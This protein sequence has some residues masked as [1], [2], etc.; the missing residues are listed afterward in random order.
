[1]VTALACT[2]ARWRPNNWAATFG[3]PARALAKAPHSLSNCPPRAL[4]KNLMKTTDK[5]ASNRVLVVDDNPSIHADFRKILCPAGRG[6][7]DNLSG[8]EAELFGD[9]PRNEPGPLFEMDSAFQ[10]Q[11]ALAMVGAAEEQGRPYSLA[12]ID[13]RMPPGWDGIES[14]TRIW[15]QF[16]ALQVVICSAYSDYSW[17]DILNRRCR[18][19]PA[20]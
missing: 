20:G 4:P 17:E 1:M 11:E 3:P 8:L 2:A 19:P 9:S 5:I 14:I 7:A 12:F 15:A 13:V 6:A 16:P 10:G 18:S